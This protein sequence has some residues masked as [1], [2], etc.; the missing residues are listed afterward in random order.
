MSA[1]PSAPR[2][3]DQPRVIPSVA[4]DG[5]MSGSSQW[6]DPVPDSHGGCCHR[7]TRN[8]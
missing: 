7:F 8:G 4:D 6:P 5:V 3:D 2:I 1:Y